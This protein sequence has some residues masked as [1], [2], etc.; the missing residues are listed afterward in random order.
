MRILCEWCPTLSL[1]GKLWQIKDKL[2]DDQLEQFEDVPRLVVQLLHNRGIAQADDMRRFL[3]GQPYA[4]SDPFRLKGMDAAV[5]RLVSA[6]REGEAIVVYGDYDADGVTATALLVQTLSALGGRVRPYIPDRIEEGYGLNMAAVS[7]LAEEGTRLLVTVD[8]GIRSVQEV[9][10]ANQLGMQVIVTD[11]HTLGDELPPALAIIN[12]KQPDCPYPFKQL[13]GVGLAF[14][15]AQALLRSVSHPSRLSEDD[16]VDLVAV[17]TVA[18]VA[19]L[20]DENRW[21]VRSGLNRLNRAPRPGLKALSEAAGIPVGRITG[22]SIGYALGPRLNAA[23]RLAS[24]QAAYELLV[25]NDPERA[26]EL[27]RQLN[28]QNQE[29]QELT[30]VAT[31]EARAFIEADRSSSLLYLIAEPYFSPGIVGLVAARLVEE[32]YRPVLVAWRGETYTRGSGRSIPGFH[33]TRALDE[34]ADLLEHHGGHSAAA[35]FTVRT[36]R[37]RQL[38]TRLL[39]IATRELAE[40]PLT[41]LLEIDAELKLDKI[42]RRRVEDLLTARAAGRPIAERELQHPGLRTLD[43]LEQMQPFGAGNPPPVFV[44]YQ[45]VVKNAYLMGG[46][47]RHL[48]LIVFDGKQE[49]EAVAFQRAEWRDRLSER[50][51]LA[52]C[53]E[54]NDYSGRQ[55]LQLGVQDIRLS[56]ERGEA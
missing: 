16:L 13:A 24:S 38:Y 48:K 8:C 53:L 28:A 56:E 23:G 22:D 3:N 45:L 41:P 29:R 33:L 50:V 39:R 6:L 40:K 20:V 44:T 17:G 31:D 11:H 32:F 51:D 43:G 18:D 15:L 19:P 12:P 10:Y 35:G 4:D 54:I 36:E 46:E 21:L 14:K 30:R 34:C 1:A 2:T 26:L 9:T 37:L 47:K 25:T 52:Y 27:A 7:R 42:D 49:W 55:R 5:T